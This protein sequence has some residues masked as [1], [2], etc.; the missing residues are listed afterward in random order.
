MIHYFKRNSTD[1][2]L[3]GSAAIKNCTKSVVMSN[4]RQPNSRNRIQKPVDVVDELDGQAP[5]DTAVPLETVI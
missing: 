4:I 3:D 2:T 5:T 1:S